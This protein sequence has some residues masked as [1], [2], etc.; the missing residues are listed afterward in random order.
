MCLFSLIVNILLS[1][2]DF[3]AADYLKEREET[4]KGESVSQGKNLFHP[5]KTSRL[6]FSNFFSLLDS[7]CNLFDFLW[8]YD[9]Y[10]LY[11]CSSK[12]RLWIFR[13]YLRKT[14]FACLYIWT[15]FERSIWMGSRCLR[16]QNVSNGR[17][18]Y[19]LFQLQGHWNVFLD[20]Y[21]PFVHFL[22]YEPDSTYH[23]LW[24]IVFTRSGSILDLNSTHQ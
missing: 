20:S 12:W 9:F 2:M 23:Y 21:I 19:V 13:N 1:T 10:V 24:N 6:I 22:P 4:L 14:H 16:A 15:C 3:K 7:N 5:G 17:H 18:F 8:S 11:E